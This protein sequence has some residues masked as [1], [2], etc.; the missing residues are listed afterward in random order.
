MVIGVVFFLCRRW[1]LE[2]FQKFLSIQCYWYEWRPTLFLSIHAPLLPKTLPPHPPPFTI[3]TGQPKCEN[4][5]LRCFRGCSLPLC[6]LHLRVQE[7]LLA[8]LEICFC[9]VSFLSEIWS[10]SNARP[11]HPPYVCNL[12]THSL[13]FYVNYCDNKHGTRKINS[14]PDPRMYPDNEGNCKGDISLRSG[15]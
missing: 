7:P 6:G 12:Q 3:N 9:Q 13:C 11:L 10:S 4:D 8:V 2:T 1:K 5:C 15:H 14:T